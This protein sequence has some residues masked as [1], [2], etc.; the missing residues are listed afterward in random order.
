MRTK[1]QK[2]IAIREHIRRIRDYLGF[3]QEAFAEHVCI[4]RPD[5]RTFFTT[6]F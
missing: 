5:F 4:S 2:L 6:N 1:Q 3:S